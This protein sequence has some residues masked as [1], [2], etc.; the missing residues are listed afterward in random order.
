[1]YGENERKRSSFFNWMKAFLSYQESCKNCTDE[2]VMWKNPE[3]ILVSCKDCSG[4]ISI[5]PK[6]YSRANDCAIYQKIE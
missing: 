4:Y 3:G 1:M 6:E 2:L 5:I